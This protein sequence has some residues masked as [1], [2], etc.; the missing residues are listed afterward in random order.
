MFLTHPVY[1]NLPKQYIRRFNF[2]SPWRAHLRQS[3]EDALEVSQH[4]FE[5]ERST[6]HVISSLRAN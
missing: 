5:E 6:G 4:P 1:Y 3:F 2:D